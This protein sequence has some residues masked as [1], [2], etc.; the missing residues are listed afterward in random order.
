MAPRTRSNPFRHC[1]LPVTCISGATP[2]TRP[3]RATSVIYPQ[4]GG[5]EPADTR[6]VTPLAVTPRP[7]TSRPV[8]SRST[9]PLRR[10][11]G[12]MGQMKSM[13]KS[14]VCQTG[15]TSDESDRGSDSEGDL[16]DR[17][18]QYGQYRQ[19]RN[20]HSVRDVQTCDRS[21]CHNHG[22]PGV[23]HFTPLFNRH[24]ANVI[25]HY[26]VGGHRVR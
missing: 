15:N 5:K 24:H 26:H 14:A 17:D 4:P 18:V 8:T 2:S 7:F 19:L 21:G 20:L 6:P 25:G 3:Y 1:C 22:G 11:T 16:S 9:T 23:V 13:L 12:A 10:T